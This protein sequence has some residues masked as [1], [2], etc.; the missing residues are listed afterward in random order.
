MILIIIINKI[1]MPEKSIINQIKNEVHRVIIG[2]DDIIEYIL[3]AIIARGHI[4]LEGVPGIAKTKMAN[5]LAKVLDLDFKRIQFTPDLLPSDITGTVIYNMSTREFDLKKGPIFTNLL[6]GDEINRASPKTQSALLECMQE[7]QVTIGNTTNYLSAPFIVIATQ[8]PLE[9]EGVYP[10][11]EAQIDRFLFKLDITY[12]TKEEEMSLIKSGSYKV[13]NINK[14]ITAKQIIE[15]GE[16]AEKVQT[17]DEILDYIVNIVTST[18]NNQNIHLGA[19]PRASIA[20][21]ETS[22]VL[23]LIEGRSYVI[24][25]DIKKL[26]FPILRHRLILSSE[27]EMS[28]ISPDQLISDILKTIPVPKALNA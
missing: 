13:E 17:T 11:P 26:A 2:K 1:I 18:R 8:N 23:A 20:F 21:L 27:A 14:I 10:L 28:E 4:L 24:P 25:D 19:S 15:I 12:P 22:K 7:R 9:M 16:I 3:V 5:T 6:L